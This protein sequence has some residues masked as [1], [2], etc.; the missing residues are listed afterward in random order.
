[1]TDK[2]ITE[3]DV[4]NAKTYMPIEKKAALARTYAQDCI[5]EVQISFDNNGSKDALPP[6][7][8]ESPM[9]KSLYGM[10]VLLTEYFNLFTSKDETEITFT[11]SDFNQWGEAAV[12]NQ[13]DRLKSSK[14][15]A[16]RNKIYDILDDY[17]EFYRMLG[18][19]IA[20]ILAAK[21]DFLSRFIEYFAS[22]VTTDLLKGTFGQLENVV[23]E[24]QE[25]QMKAG[26]SARESATEVEQ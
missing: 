11:A 15:P 22:N 25:Y 21:N 14:N 2:I 17:R 10:M 23:K 26:I 18:V 6:R 1:M 12:M 13:L 24:I 20:S 9:S 3:E 7:W 8:Q 4:L 16:V 19:E 5:V